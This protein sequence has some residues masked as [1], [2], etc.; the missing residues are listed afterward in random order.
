MLILNEK[1]MQQAAGMANVIEAVELA[2]K[3]YDEE[4]FQMDARTHMSHNENTLLLMPCAANQSLGTKIVTVFPNNK[5][6][7]VTQGL[8]ILTDGT[9]GETKAILNGTYLTGLRTGALGGLAARYLAPAGSASAGLIGTGAQGFYQLLAVCLERKIQDIYL[10]NRTQEK[11][12]AFAKDIQAHLPP[13]INIHIMNQPDEVV[14]HSNII[15]AATTSEAPVLP[16]QPD[17][18][19][20]KLVI[21]VGSFQPHM[22][23]LPES[24][25]KQA[26]H[27]F[28]DTL[29]AIHETGDVI[30]PIKNRWLV[31]SQLIPF[32][33]VVTGKVKPDISMEKPLIFKSTGMAL[34][35]VVA[36]RA[37]YEKAAQQSIGQEIDF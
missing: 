16:N 6:H 34:F 20:G 4:Q 37:I 19:N 33:S 21:G 29:D 31:E 10:Y 30:D 1:S 24:L 35:D 11:A 5:D 22:R 28:I 14:T 25:F 7:P 36:A 8:M 18:Y 27:L 32:S 12:A 26:D 15:I 17:I 2:Y 13:H 3:L 23:E 9:N